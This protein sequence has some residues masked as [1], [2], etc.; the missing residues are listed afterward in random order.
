VSGQ[1]F[2]L[3]ILWQYTEKSNAQEANWKEGNA[4]NLVRKI[5]WLEIVRVKKLCGLGKQSPEYE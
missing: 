1:G 4:R 2:F 3:I 5:N